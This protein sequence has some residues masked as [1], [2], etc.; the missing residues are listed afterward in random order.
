MKRVC[1]METATAKTICGKQSSRKKKRYM[2]GLRRDC[3][4]DELQSFRFLFNLGRGYV[5]V[6]KTKP[7]RTH[8][9][10]SEIS[11]SSFDGGYI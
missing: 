4:T 8:N 5:P 7:P 6:T 2:A 1:N 9:P 11:S 3:R 10:D